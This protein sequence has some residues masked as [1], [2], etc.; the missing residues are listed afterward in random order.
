[1]SLRDQKL[2]LAELQRVLIHRL[3]NEDAEISEVVDIVIEQGTRHKASDIH[4]VMTS[5]SR[6][7]WENW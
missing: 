6:G 1:M 5:C 2:E 3:V 4:S 7:K